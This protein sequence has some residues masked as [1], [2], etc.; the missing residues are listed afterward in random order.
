M[1]RNP[2][3]VTDVAAAPGRRSHV[4]RWVA[5]AVGVPAVAL[6]GVLATQPPAATRSAES[7]LLGK[8]APPLAGPTIDG[9]DFRL[10]DRR[11]RWVLVNFF[12]TWCVP[13]RLEH[14]ELVRFEERHARLGD[15]EVV[16]VI[17]DDSPKAV[18][19]FRD[20][21]GGAWPMVIDPKG[22][23]ALDFGVA[24]VPESYLVDPRGVVAAKVVGGV[25]ADELESLLARARQAQT[26]T[27][28]DGR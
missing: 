7:P 28:K 20:R 14:P 23:I 6:V 19:E 9:E 18:R 12:A 16:T 27:R 10:A 11:G 5:L 25:R 3:D 13:C 1:R 24:G 17:Y 21:E 8:P 22:R 2:E 26:E 15:A 4:V